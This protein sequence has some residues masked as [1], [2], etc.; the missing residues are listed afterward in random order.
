MPIS[1]RSCVPGQI[2]K[3][4]RL[5]SDDGWAPVRLGPIGTS[6]VALQEWGLWTS[7]CS[8]VIG[9]LKSWSMTTDGEPGQDARIGASHVSCACAWVAAVDNVNTPDLRS[10]LG[11]L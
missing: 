9:G 2:A 4:H 7:T 5:R 1:R 3:G 10:E 8:P 11:Y 6:V